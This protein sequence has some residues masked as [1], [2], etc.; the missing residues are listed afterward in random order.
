MKWQA[1]LA[2][3]F[4]GFTLVSSCMTKPA[5]SFE[6]TVRLQAAIAE[7]GAPID[8]ETLVAR[9]DQLLDRIV[10]LEGYFQLECEIWGKH[11]CTYRNELG[12]FSVVGTARLPELNSREQP[13]YPNQNTYILLDASLPTSFG[14]PDSRRVIVKGRFVEATERLPD[15]DKSTAPALIREVREYRLDDTEVIALYHVTCH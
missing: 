15:P 11:G 5:A 7:F 9:R 1:V 3:T 14:R 2:A 4:F 6:Q 8:P 10:L 12:R 13:C